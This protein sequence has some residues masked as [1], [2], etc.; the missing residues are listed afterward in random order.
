MKKPK[1]KYINYNLGLYDI[2]AN[3]IFLHK[4]LKKDKVVHN[5]FLNHELDH[6]KRK[7]IFLVDLEYLFNY[8][9]VKEMCRFIF[10]HPATLIHGFSP[11]HKVEGNWR[12]NISFLIMWIIIICLIISLLN[13]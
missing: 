8:H 12:I 4:D 6:W 3:T 1:I 7:S 2:K 5:L 11:F 13:K 9:Y 10:K